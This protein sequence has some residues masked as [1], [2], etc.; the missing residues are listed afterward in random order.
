MLRTMWDTVTL[1]Q[2]FAAS[3]VMYLG[4]ACLMIAIS[5]G[6]Q[7]ASAECGCM[8]PPEKICEWVGEAWECVCPDAPA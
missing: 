1:G 2:D 8:C 7:E 3:A 6:P 4:I 5:P